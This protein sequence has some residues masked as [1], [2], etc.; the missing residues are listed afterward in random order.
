MNDS[1]S[2]TLAL[3]QGGHASRALAFDARGRVIGQAAET[4]ATHR[5]GERV[6]QDPEEMVASLA[7]AARRIT[8][9]IGHCHAAGL[10]TQR[11]SIVCW[12]RDTGRALTP[13]L[14]WQDRRAAE[15]LLPLEAHKEQVGRITGL[16]L[17]P[18]YGAS[19]L[20]WCLDNVP[21]V[22][23]A[24]KRSN[25]AAGPLASFLLARLLEEEP[26]LA[27]PANAARTL[28]YDRQ[29]YDWSDPMLSMF[30]LPR[31][32]LPE[33]VPSRHRFGHLALDGAATPLTVCTGDQSAA[34]FAAGSPAPGTVVVNAGTGVFL[35]QAVSAAA[36]P[37]KLLAG[38]AW[39][40]VATTVHTLEGSVN[41]GGAALT[42]VARQEG[43]AERD[44]LDR[45]PE[46]LDENR[47]P[48]LFLNGVGGL[49]SPFWRP[50]FGTRFV[51]RGDPGTRLA[52]VVE[53]IAFL[54]RINLEA[55]NAVGA[56]VRR[57]V[58]TGGLARLDGFARRLAILGGVP[59]ERPVTTEATARGLAW[60]VAGRPSAWRVATGQRDEPGEDAALERRYRRW[61]RAMDAA[62]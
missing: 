20:A 15:R 50:R 23:R 31:D 54:V 21:A 32:M 3:D 2:Y 14:S 52:A 17:S 5:D 4:V 36:N 35:Q 42:Q 19:K 47:E 8:A 38:L 37:G 34:L 30:G 60:L 6:E 56:P 28:L 55:M 51:G 10:A 59:V 45:L 12:E 26:C 39:H 29:Q 9:D 27:D 46:A 1:E 57:I 11:S 22:R 62:L 16:R 43:I 41:G 33:A 13:V 25:L 58:L 48:P 61:R 7:A 40:G 24:R 18:H 44:M 53:S 49:G